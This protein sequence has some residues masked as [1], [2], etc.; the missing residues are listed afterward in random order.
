[1]ARDQCQLGSSIKPLITSSP[2]EH[3]EH[4]RGESTPPSPDRRLPS[5]DRPT[6][7]LGEIAKQRSGTSSR[8]S[9]TRLNALPAAHRSRGRVVQF[10]GTFDA[11]VVTRRYCAD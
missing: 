3:R 7:Q 4:R 6:V 9:I 8:T 10:V 2:P 5:V 11:Y 1:M